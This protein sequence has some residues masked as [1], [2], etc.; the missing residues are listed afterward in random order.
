M[1]T[2]FTA[3]LTAASAALLSLPS[4][5]QTRICIGGDLDHLSAPERAACS[6]TA[7]A[8][9]NEATSLHAPKGWH[10]V[11]VCG[12]EG[13]K[14]YAAFSS[15]PEALLE[16]AS[17]DTD[18]DQQTTYLRED[19]LRPTQHEGLHRIVAHEVASILLNTD[20]EV[21]IQAQMAR[22]EGAQHSQIALLQR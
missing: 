10:F 7:Q 18:R 9:R 4:V 12:E 13:W 19:R 14:S 1:R 15:H 17:V 2:R 20:S 3:L 8:V 21:A 11:V 5:A 16:N 22:W 6:A